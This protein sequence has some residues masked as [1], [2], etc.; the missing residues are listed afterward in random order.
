MREV[1]KPENAMMVNANHVCASQQSQYV[2]VLSLVKDEITLLLIAL[3]FRLV[4]VGCS[5]LTIFCSSFP[6]KEQRERSKY[7]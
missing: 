7:S 3:L 4:V 6:K 2:V 5:V 1:K